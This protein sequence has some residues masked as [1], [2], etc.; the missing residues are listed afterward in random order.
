MELLPTIWFIA[1][2]VL[3]TGYLF[4]EGFDLGVGMLM[5]V[6]ARNNTE[7][8]VL[9]NTIGPV[10]DGNEVWLL[11]AGGATFAAFPLWYAS[12]F[13]AL[14]LPLLLVLVALIFRA[15]AFEYRG[16]VDTP[17]WRARW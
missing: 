1:I 3:W 2:A 17:Q 12:L 9:L 15:V 14:Y 7:R 5:K 6:F 10:W 16:K 4:L 11:T 8:R 13:S